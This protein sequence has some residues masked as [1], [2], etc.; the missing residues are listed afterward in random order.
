MSNWPTVDQ[1]IGRWES[2]DVSGAGS[3]FSLPDSG[4]RADAPPAETPLATPSAA[5][6]GSTLDVLLPM[7]NPAIADTAEPDAP[8]G[9]DADVPPGFDEPLPPSLVSALAV[10]SGAVEYDEPDYAAPPG[11]GDPDFEEG[12]VLSLSGGPS[13]EDV[14][15]DGDQ[16]EPELALSLA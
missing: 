8:A 5:R 7:Q 3:E 6:P 12:G 14:G 4:P 16:Y 11:L 15:L 1:L 13:P 10:E 9:S 2:P